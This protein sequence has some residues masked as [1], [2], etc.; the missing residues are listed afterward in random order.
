[1][2]TAKT[3]GFLTA[4]GAWAGI[5]LGG[6]AL[7]AEP[8]ASS[9]RGMDVNHDGYISRDEHAAAAK[10]MFA[11]MDASKDGRVTAA[12]MD[13]AQERVTGRKAKTGDMAAADKI[14]VIDKDGDGVLTADEHAAG[15]RSMFEA[16]D[17]DKSGALSEAEFSAGHAKMLKK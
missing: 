11:A 15:S 9:F 16:M 1:M 6:H 12:E 14:K 17:S 3:R 5:A 10:G 2:R 8:A 13:A 4:L 7:A